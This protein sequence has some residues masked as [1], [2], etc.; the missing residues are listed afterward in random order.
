MR[1]VV[2]S[3]AAVLVTAALMMVGLAA[4]TNTESPG[5]ATSAPP[6]SSGSTPS[7]ESTLGSGGHAAAM[8]VTKDATIAALVPEDIRKS[9][10][11]TL[12][13]DPTYAPIDF[14]NDAGDIIGL[15]PDIALAVANKMGLR[16]QNSRADFNGILAG[17]Q[18]HRWD[19]SFASFSITADRTKVVDMV[20]F[21][22]DTTAVMTQKGNPHHITSE[23][24]LCGLTVSVQTGTTQA[25]SSIPEF[26]KNCAA[27]GLKAVNPMVVPQQDSANQ[28]LISGRAQAMVADRALVAYY[29]LLKPDA[30]DIAPGISIDPSLI[31][32]AMP[33]GDGTLA[34]A[35]QAALQSIIDDGTYRKILT[36]WNLEGAAVTTAQIDPAAG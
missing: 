23:D 32:V 1:H 30:Y 34:K 9:G 7:A 15:E 35:F 20:S 19:A 13:T 18:S 10:V 22:S 21:M 29:T 27:K 3:K 8:A 31:G 12:V 36:S 6:S 2:V 17:L 4:C 25:L 33:K 28:A 11:L 14:T 16:M 5:G 26:Q 24:K